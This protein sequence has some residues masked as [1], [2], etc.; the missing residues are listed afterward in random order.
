MKF[1]FTTLFVLFFQF[2]FSQFSVDFSGGYAVPFSGGH[3]PFSKGKGI[4]FF[5]YYTKYEDY[6]YSY[7]EI[8]QRDK[9]DYYL[10]NGVLACYVLNSGLNFNFSMGYQ[11]KSWFKISLGVFYLNNKYL[12]YEKKGDDYILT[13]NFYQIAT[14]VTYSDSVECQNTRYEHVKSYL[15]II[16]PLVRFEFIKS[17]KKMD[18]S[19]FFNQGISFFELTQETQYVFHYLN[20]RQ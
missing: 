11:P 14:H 1:A 18:I 6:G 7:G 9:T 8:Y 17:F 5:P 20:Y 2:V 3:Q 12:P 13:N 10:D 16:T 19:F 4:P 15:Q